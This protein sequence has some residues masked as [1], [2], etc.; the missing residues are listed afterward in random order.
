MQRS[1]APGLGYPARVQAAAGA[2]ILATER[3]ERRAK[4]G[5]LFEQLLEPPL[6]PAP[7]LSKARHS[8]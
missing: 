2:S 3:F 7:D 4:P 5:Q 6:D 1:D 8:S